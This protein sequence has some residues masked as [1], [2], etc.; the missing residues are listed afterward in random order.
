MEAIIQGL[1]AEHRDALAAMDRAQQ[2]VLA[3]AAQLLID[4]L[5]AGRFIYVCGNGGSAADA[6]HIAA[7][8]GGRFLRE[9]KSL[10]C[11]ALSTN[12]STLTAVGND[13]AYADVFSR[14]VEG[15][16]RPGDVLWGITT[17]GNSANVLQAAEAARKLG[18][19]ILGFTGGAGGKLPP[20]CDV[21]FVAPVKTTYGIQ[22]LHLL[23]Y[24]ILCD[25]V[26]R[27]FAPPR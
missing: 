14:Q 15:L 26:E 3:S 1:I 19:R 11:I 6:Q 9:R 23:A 4:A 24:H 27:A 7:E 2:T 20:L 18:A 13:Y 22:Q 12:T 21:C 17:S 8:L 5:Q 16:V 25:L 10:P